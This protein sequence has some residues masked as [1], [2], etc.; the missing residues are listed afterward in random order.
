MIYE[1]IKK[2][3]IQAMKDKKLSCGAYLLLERLLS[4][5]GITR[6]EFKLAKYEKAYISN[7]EDIYFN[8]SHSSKMVACAI[9]DMEVGVDVELNDPTIDLDIA[10]NYFFNEEYESI[11][12][13][14]NSADEFFSY[15]VLKES[16]MK[17]T[18][19]GFNL[20]LDSF[21]ICIGDKIT[22][23]D[24]N[25]NLKF[26]LFDIEEYK[27]GICS[28]YDVKNP[29]EYKIIDGFRLDSGQF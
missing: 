27:L 23:K 14:S 4:E 16:Y 1:Q 17:Y 18:G 13:S 8:M 26:N 28:Q 12:N 6:P 7:Y 10:K 24:D 11:M 3:N 2:D 22:L 9:S 21:Q 5:V 19:L 25:D 29:I 15:W 20:S